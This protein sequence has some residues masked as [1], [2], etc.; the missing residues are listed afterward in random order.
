M[1][2]VEERQGPSNHAPPVR[3]PSCRKL[4][5]VLVFDSP[6]AGMVCAGC[7]RRFIGLRQEAVLVPK[8]RRTELVTTTTPLRC[9]HC[10]E[11]AFVFVDARPMGLFCQHCHERMTP[12][13]E[14]PGAGHTNPPTLR[15]TRT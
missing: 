5:P 1:H 11:F 4:A 2:L 12:W 6:A 9:A 3:C 8:H 15:R 10:Q 7:H 14:E 13:G